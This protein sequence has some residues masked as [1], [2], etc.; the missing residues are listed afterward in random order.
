MAVIRDRALAA[1]FLVAS[2]WISASASE[3]GSSRRLLQTGC[4]VD[5]SKLDYSPITSVCKS[6]YPQDTCC[7]AYGQF[8]SPHKSEL[9]DLSRMCAMYFTSY[10]NMAGTYPNGVFIGR[11]NSGNNVCN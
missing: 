6:P 8:C 2:L 9:N 1:L 4:S 11:C 10:L 3:F 7:N 5:Y